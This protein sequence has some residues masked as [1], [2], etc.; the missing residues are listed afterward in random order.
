M[1]VWSQARVNIPAGSDFKVMLTAI[2]GDTNG[3]WVAV[4][5]FLFLTG[6]ED[7]DIIPPEAD[8]NPSTTTPAGETTHYPPSNKTELYNYL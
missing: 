7:C 6:V 4:D 3:G 2:R 1:E 8:P 5:D